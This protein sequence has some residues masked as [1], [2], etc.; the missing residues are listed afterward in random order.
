MSY[1]LMD[2]DGKLQG[3]N[4]GIRGGS[5][6]DP[7][8]CA[9]NCCDTAYP[10]SLTNCC[11]VKESNYITFGT[12]T[13]YIEQTYLSGYKDAVTITISSPTT[14]NHVAGT[15]CGNIVCTAYFSYTRIFYNPN[16]TVNSTGS[17]SRIDLYLRPVNNFSTYSCSEPNTN[18]PNTGYPFLRFNLNDIS[19][20]FWI[21]FGDCFNINSGTNAIYTAYGFS[22]HPTITGTCSSAISIGPR[23]TCCRSGESCI[24]GSSNNDGSCVEEGI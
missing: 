11:F 7:C 4:G 22:P 14:V 10:S 8:C 1:L 18:H 17:G 15:C 21:A 6:G 23:P 19:V 12:G 5:T 13:I 3:Y 2:S 16:G 24:S 20:S 9:S